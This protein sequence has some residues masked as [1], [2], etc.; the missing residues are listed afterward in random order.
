MLALLRKTS[1]NSQTRR[2]Y[3]Q[4]STITQSHLSSLLLAS[5]T[6]ASLPS[7]ST[8][9]GPTPTNSSAITPS[10]NPGDD[11]TQIITTSAVPSLSSLLEKMPAG[12][13]FVGGG[14]ETGMNAIGG[15]LPPAP[16]NKVG[17]KWVPRHG[18]DIPHD[19]EAY[20]PMIGYN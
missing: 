3:P 11:A 18:G 1:N 7:P 9:P 20:F 16:P 8:A 13:A 12:Q 19:P 4:T 17:G 14:V 5:P 15:G 6:L 2:A 10:S